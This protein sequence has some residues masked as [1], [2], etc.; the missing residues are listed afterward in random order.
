MN[1]NLTSY[2][3]A[4]LDKSRTFIRKLSL[5]GNALTTFAYSGIGI[6]PKLTTLNLG[7]NRLE[8]IPDHAFQHPKL[9]ILVLSDN[10]IQAVGAYAFFAL[11][12]LE[13]LHLTGTRITRLGNYVLTLG[14]RVPE[15]KVFLSEGNLAS[16]S[17]LAFSDTRAQILCLGQNNLTE[18]PRDVFLPI[19][20]RLERRR[21]ATGEVSSLRVSG[22]P[23]SC[24]GCSFK[25]L[26][27]IKNQLLSRQLL[28]GF[29]CADGTTLAKLSYTKI[30]C[31]PQIVG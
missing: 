26:V 15:L 22:N 17:P 23:F 21:Q 10:P 29:E 4:S 31:W 1:A 25:W 27:R 28:S 7:K 30:G 11:P 16:L 6:F 13:M 14:S 9:K 3:L 8:R 20:E 19:L 24:T 5:F 12:E 2:N 18:F